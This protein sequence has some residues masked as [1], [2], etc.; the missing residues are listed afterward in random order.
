MKKEPLVFE[1]LDE[2]FKTI[3]LINPI[4]KGRFSLKLAYHEKEGI[5]L[6][7]EELKNSDFGCYVPI[8]SISNILSAEKII[9]LNGK[10]G[11]VIGI[12]DGYIHLHNH[13]SDR[14]EMELRALMHYLLPYVK[15]PH[16]GAYT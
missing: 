7:L 2:S 1:V 16:L 11:I 8:R 4:N 5:V 12:G 3:P 10:G 15:N 6:L 13:G 14:V 9:E